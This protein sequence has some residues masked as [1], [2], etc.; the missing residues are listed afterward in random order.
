METPGLPSQPMASHPDISTASPQDSGASG[1]TPWS[2][3][4]APSTTEL[5]SQ[6]G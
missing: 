1:D 6:L 4:E 5:L 2:A 3:A